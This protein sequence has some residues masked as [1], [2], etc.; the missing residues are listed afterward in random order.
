MVRRIGLR[1]VGQIDHVHLAAR[2]HHRADR[3][4]AEP[5]HARDHGALAGLQDAG[6]L[7]L[8]DQGANFLLG[9]ALLRPPASGRA[10]AETIAAGEIEQPYERR[11]DPSPASIIAGATLTAIR[12]GLRSAICLGTS[13]PRIRET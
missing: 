6:G 7:G 9:D 2:R 13:S 10:R 12:S 8:G 1:I 5:H 4:V 3:A 11:R